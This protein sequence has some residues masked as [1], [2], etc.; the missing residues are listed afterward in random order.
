MLQKHDYM[1]QHNVNSNIQV[2]EDLFDEREAIS[3]F[4]SI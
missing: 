3:D 2:V 4:C 1:I